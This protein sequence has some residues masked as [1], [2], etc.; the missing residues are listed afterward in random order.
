MIYTSYF[1]RMNSKKYSHLKNKAISIARGNK[2]W[3]GDTYPELFPSWDIITKAHD[4][5]ITKEEYEKIYKTEVLDKLD[6]A[7]V[8]EDLNDRI[9][10]CWEKTDDIK[11][12]DTFCHRYI[13]AQ[14]LRDNGFD[15]QE[16]E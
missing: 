11:T 16:L 15:A 1:G 14:W 2:Y 12:G 6:P 10:I 3:E 9:L 7:K 13:V 4:K 5:T 8:Y